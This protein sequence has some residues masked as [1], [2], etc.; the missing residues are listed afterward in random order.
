MSLQSY[1][2][3]SFYL[4]FQGVQAG[5]EDRSAAKVGRGCSL[6]KPA[7]TGRKKQADQVKDVK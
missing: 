6:S 2:Q 3:S 5:F 1:F 4:I 7:P